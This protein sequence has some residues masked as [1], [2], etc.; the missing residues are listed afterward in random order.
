MLLFRFLSISFL[1]HGWRSRCAR[2]RSCILTHTY[3]LSKLGEYYVTLNHHL[4]SLPSL[5]HFTRF[6]YYVW[7]LQWHSSHLL[8]RSTTRP[9]QRRCKSFAF[10]TNIFYSISSCHGALALGIALAHEAYVQLCS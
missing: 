5:L 10:L 9:I 2:V 7:Q 3:A 8:C 4:C 1:L 6:F